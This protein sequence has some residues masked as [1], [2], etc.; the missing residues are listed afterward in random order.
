MSLSSSCLC[1]PATVSRARA[2]C[3]STPLERA[4]AIE[5]RLRCQEQQRML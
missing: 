1:N 2:I 5:A 3:F 4:T